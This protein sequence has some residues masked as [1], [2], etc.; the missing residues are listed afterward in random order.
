[1][2]FAGVS[3]WSRSLLGGTHPLLSVIRKL[4]DFASALRDSRRR[5]GDAPVW[6]RGHGRASWRLVPSAHRRALGREAEL[7]AQFVLRA[8]ARR[9]RCPAPDDLASWLPLMRHSGL[10]TRLLDWTDSPIV[11]AFFT[12]MYERHAGD[13]ALWLLHP[14]AL[15]HES[16][17]DEVPFLE[18]ESV[19]PFL[20]H[21][22]GRGR[23]HSGRDRGE[24]A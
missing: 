17:L 1:L 11:A 16:G 9:A 13:R 20:A 23:P 8:P 15:N 12:A 10:P 22:F 18:H 24:R 5:R 14:L 3:L 6:C 2:A 19:R 7:A 21:A 4:E